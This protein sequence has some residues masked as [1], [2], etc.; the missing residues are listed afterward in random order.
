MM[1]LVFE[2][3][4]FNYLADL[5]LVTMDDWV[6]PVCAKP[7]VDNTFEIYFDWPVLPN[8]SCV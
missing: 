6:K 1:C 2:Y 7:Y 4:L 5:A 8:C 3:Y